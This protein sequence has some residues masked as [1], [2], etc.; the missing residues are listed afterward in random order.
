MEDK[1]NNDVKIRWIKTGG[2][3]FRLANGKIIKPN[4]KFSARPDEIPEAF[5]DVIIPIDELP[6]DIKTPASVP[7]V[8]KLQKRSVGWFDVVDG[9]G[10]ILNEQALRRDAALKLIKG[11]E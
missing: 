6:E 8:Y 10:K 11:L 2:G 5:R 3:R 4:Q 7:A 1:N 9:N